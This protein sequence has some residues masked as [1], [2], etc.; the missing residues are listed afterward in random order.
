MNHASAA[1]SRTLSPV[2]IGIIIVYLV[3]IRTDS[4]AVG[5]SAMN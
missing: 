2:D 3:S 1:L 5:S 4:S